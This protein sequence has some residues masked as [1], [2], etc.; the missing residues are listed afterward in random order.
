MPGQSLNLPPGPNAWQTVQQVKNASPERLYL[1]E[2]IHRDY[3]DI[4]HVNILGGHYFMLNNPEF[5]RLVL[6]EQSAAFHS[7]PIGKRKTARALDPAVVQEERTFHKQQ[8]RILQPAFTPS[9]VARYGEVMVRYATEAAQGWQPDTTYDL[10]DQMNRLTLR[11][12]ARTLF[13]ADVSDSNDAFSVAVALGSEYVAGGSRL[14]FWI[15]TAKNRQLIGAWLRMNNTINRVVAE[16]RK[17]GEDR[18]DLLSAVLLATDTESGAK[19]TEQQAQGTIMGLFIA[20]HE[21]TANA[22]I[23]TWVLLAQHPD[24]VQKLH[25]ELDQVLA[26][27]AP[28]AADVEHLPYT[29]TIIREAL[30]LYPPAWVLN[31]FAVTTTQIGGYD[32]PKGSQLFMSPYVMQRDA[33]FY[34]DPESFRPERWLDGDLPL[35]KRLPPYA[36]YPFGGGAHVCIG[37]FFAMLELRL[38]LATLAQR[39]RIQLLP[40]QQI[41]VQPLITLRPDKAIQVQITL[42]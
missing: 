25:A 17:S 1:L 19:L 9:N 24:I 11:I 15:P 10:S 31:R 22:I 40:D 30:R 42:R 26:G 6:V 13:D 4:A 12:V 14:P 16:R 18:G 23:W 36:Y 32:I 20:G 7:L 41:G 38:L 5:V 39:V 34:D 29:D 37:Q 3:G 28:T 33:R 35:E 2:R 27:R 8:R 21:T